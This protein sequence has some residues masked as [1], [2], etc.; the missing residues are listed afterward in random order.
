[1]RCGNEGFNPLWIAGKRAIG[2][3]KGSEEAA[4][5]ARGPAAELRPSQRGRGAASA[6]KKYLDALT[7]PTDR[8]KECAAAPLPQSRQRSLDVFA[9][10]KTVGTMIEA[11]AGIGEILEATD[12]HLVSAPAAGSDAV[13]SEKRL[14]RFDWLDGEYLGAATPPAQSNLVFVGGPP[15]LQR[16]SLKHGAGLATCA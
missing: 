6:A 16:G 11:A 7:A 14:T 9:R 15:S 1:M 2:I 8:L 12:F 13:R 3:E 4:H 5:R 10:P